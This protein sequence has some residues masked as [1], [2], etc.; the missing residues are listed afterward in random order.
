MDHNTINN[1]N[2]NNNDN[3][4]FDEDAYRGV[5]IHSQVTKV[6]LEMEKI[7]RLALQQPE[8][9]P[10]LRGIN[11]QHHRSRSPLGLAQRPISVGN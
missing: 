4:S 5:G 1:N 3:N 8:A 11:R 6:K 7:N 9:R 2:N 10:A